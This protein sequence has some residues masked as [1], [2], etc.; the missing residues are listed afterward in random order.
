MFCTIS[1]EVCQHPV[2]S[3]KTGHIYERSLLEKHLNVTGKCPVTED[4]M[5]MDDI[6]EVQGYQQP[7]QPKPPSSS[8]IP[9]LL[10]TLQNEVCYIYI[11][12]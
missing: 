11:Y 9:V 2:I 10:K 8:S 4:N 7:S 5:T 6:I 12:I 3:K 1:N